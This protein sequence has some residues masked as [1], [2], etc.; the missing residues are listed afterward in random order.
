MKIEFICDQG[1]MKTISKYYVFVRTFSDNDFIIMLL[2]VD[3]IIIVR[4][5]YLVYICYKRN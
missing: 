5:T 3:D 4:K 2:Y 1:Y